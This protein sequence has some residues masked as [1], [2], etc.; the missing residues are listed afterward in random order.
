L[1]SLPSDKVDDDIVVVADVRY[2]LLCDTQMVSFDPDTSN[3]D[4]MAGYGVAVVG[5]YYQ[6]KHDDDG[7]AIGLVKCSKAECSSVAR[8]TRAKGEKH[9]L[10]HLNSCYQT[11]HFLPHGFAHVIY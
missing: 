4:E 7:T 1:L 2:S 10:T 6:V 3:M 8:T 11:V 5:L 9:R